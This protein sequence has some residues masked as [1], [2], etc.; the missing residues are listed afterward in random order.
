LRSA[1]ETAWW[2]RK[3]RRR[4]SEWSAERSGSEE[5]QPRSGRK[6]MRSGAWRR[7]RVERIRRASAGAEGAEERAL[8]AALRSVSGGGG[9]GGRRRR[10]GSAG[11]GGEER[12]SSAAR[13]WWW[14]GDGGEAGSARRTANARS[15][16]GRARALGLWWRRCSRRRS[17]VLGCHP[18]GV[19]MAEEKDGGGG[20]GSP[21]AGGIGDGEMAEYGRFSWSAGVRA[22]ALVV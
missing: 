20:V 17:A 11:G 15:S 6:L 22:S 12:R 21:P 4:S 7:R 2:E 9:S 14:C 5:A 18:S 8:T 1:R 19:V 10:R 16:R 3:P 13:E